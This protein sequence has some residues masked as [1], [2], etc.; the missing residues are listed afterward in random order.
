MI[1]LLAYD[2]PSGLIVS[3]ESF[4]DAE[5]VHAERARLALEMDPRRKGIDRE[6]LLL[7]AVNEE[8]LRRTHRRYFETPIQLSSG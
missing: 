1:F 3:L 5:Q 7:Q 8:A 4:P 2:R 6:V